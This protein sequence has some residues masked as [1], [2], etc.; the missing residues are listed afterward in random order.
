MTSE[1]G[2]QPHLELESEGEYTEDMLEAGIT[3]NNND[4]L[5]KF[6]MANY[7]LFCQ[8]LWYLFEEIL[9]AGGLHLAFLLF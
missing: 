2:E 6:S 4:Y 3:F 8:T 7:R 1:A 9:R 5:K